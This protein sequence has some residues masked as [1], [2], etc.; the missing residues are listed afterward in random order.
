MWVA[1]SVLCFG[2]ILEYTNLCSFFKVISNKEYP[3]S[4]SDFCYAL[5][6]VSARDLSVYRRHQAIVG[7]NTRFAPTK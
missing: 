2:R 6:I 5:I 3:L 7:A 4:D 1:G